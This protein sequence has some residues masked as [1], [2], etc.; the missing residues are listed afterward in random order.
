MSRDKDQ[1]RRDWEAIQRHHQQQRD[2]ARDRAQQAAAAREQQ[3]I[4]AADRKAKNEFLGLLGQAH[5]MSDAE[6]D[7]AIKKFGRKTGRKL[8]PADRKKIKRARG[9]KGLFS[10]LFGGK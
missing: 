5:K 6:M 7:Q 8:T 4:Y 2:A 9:G 3:E 1:D 10:W